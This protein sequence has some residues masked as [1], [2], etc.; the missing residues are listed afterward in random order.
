M[1]ICVTGGAGF[2]GSRLIGLLLNKGYEVDV[3]DKLL[4]GD[5]GVL[6]YKNLSNYHLHRIDIRD[7]YRV[8]KVL[9]DADYLIHLAAYVGD[10]LCERYPRKAWETNVNGTKILAEA[11]EKHSIPMILASTCSNYGVT[12]GLATEKTPLN[13]QGKYAESKVAAEKIVSK[14]TPHIILRFATLYGMSPRMRLDLMLNEW[15][16]N[17]LQDGFIEIYQPD[18][19]RPTINVSDAAKT[20]VRMLETIKEDTRETYNVG[21]ND[22]NFTKREL[23]EIIRGEIDGEITYVEKGDPRNYRVSFNKAS[24]KMKHITRISPR[25]SVLT[26]KNF[27]LSTRDIS[28]CHNE[29]GFYDTRI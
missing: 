29:K 8:G 15:T 23:A 22:Y 19:Y 18:A 2:L 5:A 7:S 6:P 4:Y 26:V 25:V 10:P 21:F 13:P 17:M 28:R 12:D 9:L 16:M 20:V 11:A 3:I 14:H 1:K 24:P 27:V